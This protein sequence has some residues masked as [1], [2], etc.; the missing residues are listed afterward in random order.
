MQ[1]HSTVGTEIPLT[2]Y[3]QCQRHSTDELFEYGKNMKSA[4]QE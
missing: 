2:S 3:A 1:S 4:A